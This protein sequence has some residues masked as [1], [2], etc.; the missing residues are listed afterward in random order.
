LGGEVVNPITEYDIL[1][2]VRNL[3]KF[4]YPQIC[5][6]LVAADLLS[7]LDSKGASVSADLAD[8]VVNANDEE[9]L[10]LLGEVTP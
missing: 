1:N 10:R 2:M 3:M 7:L 8:A 4:R 5:R 9:A 6:H